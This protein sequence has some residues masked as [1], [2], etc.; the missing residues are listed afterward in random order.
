[1]FQAKKSNI[2]PR[3]AAGGWGGAGIATLGCDAA[4]CNGDGSNFGG[5]SSPDG[6]FL[7]AKRREPG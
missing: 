6:R 3:L 1:M 7:S 5:T 4:R 2:P